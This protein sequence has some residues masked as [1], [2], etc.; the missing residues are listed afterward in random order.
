MTARGTL[1][2]PAA[3]SLCV[4]EHDHTNC[5]S[6]CP[7]TA[8]DLRLCAR[9][10][11]AA[12]TAGTSTRFRQFSSRRSRARHARGAARV[13]GRARS[14]P[15]RA[16]RSSASSRPTFTRNAR[17]RARRCAAAR[18]PEMEIAHRR[19][20]DL[21]REGRSC[22]TRRRWSAAGDRAA[23]SSLAV[24]G[25][26]RIA[27]SDP[28]ALAPASLKIPSPRVWNWRAAAI[29]RRNPWPNERD[30]AAGTARRRTQ[31]PLTCTPCGVQMHRRRGAR[32]LHPPDRRCSTWAAARS[33]VFR[34]AEDRAR[35]LS[36]RVMRW[37][38]SRRF[39]DA[40]SRPAPQRWVREHRDARARSRQQGL[41]DAGA[42]GGAGALRCSVHC[43]RA[44]V[45][46]RRA[47]D[48]RAPSGGTFVVHEYVDYR[49]WR[50]FAQPGV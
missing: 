28:L 15:R 14:R 50:R 30:Y 13:R 40:F 10:R 19:D 46:A 38:R 43:A 37:T 16:G 35:A 9:R 48:R 24:S 31:P 3:G 23:R 45:A 42:D 4:G 7:R 6:V 49:T 25:P 36:I 26:V 27:A 29:F 12:L 2:R 5:G 21:R 39:L 1:P 18:R 22:G 32:R 41:P 8:A 33:V 17:G 11:A 44:A 20:R 34:P 47:D